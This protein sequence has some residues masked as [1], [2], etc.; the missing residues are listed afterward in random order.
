VK[1]YCLIICLIKFNIIILAPKILVKIMAEY[2]SFIEQQ[3]VNILKISGLL[4]PGIEKVIAIYYDQTLKNICAKFIKQNSSGLQIE[5]FLINDSSK[6]IEE[7]RIKKEPVNW[8]KKGE[9]PFETKDANKIIME[10]FSE[11]ENVVLLMRFYNEDD[12]KSDL[13]FFYFN[14]NAGNFEI[15]KSN[16]SLSVKNKNIIEFLLY[17]SIKTIMETNRQ[18]FKILQLLIENMKSNTQNNNLIKEELK[19]TK[20]RYGQSLENL[21][22]SY[23]EEISS[24]RNKEFKLTDDALKKISNY[25]GDINN[26]KIIMERAISCIENINFENDNE[27]LMINEWDINFNLKTKPDENKLIMTDKYTKTE[28]LLDKLEKASQEAKSN[29]FS[30]TSANVGKLLPT[31]ITA[32]AISDALK[33]HKKTILYLLKKYPDKWR[34]IR[35][36]FRPLLNIITARPNLEDYYN[37]ETGN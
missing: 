30:L 21:C 28:L 3:I 12:K 23:V 13:L 31:P 35:N 22:K 6:I 16:K 34:I 14:K 18:D 27:V 24:Q 25:D 2:F 10:I 36:E 37:S 17:N 4:I 15:C 1:K 32:P 11:L 33:K 8:Y 9:L 7:L 5:D 26:L 19:I 29:N 20:K